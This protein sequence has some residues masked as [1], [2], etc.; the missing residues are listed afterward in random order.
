MFDELAALSSP[1]C[2]WWNAVGLICFAAFAL[3]A[4]SGLGGGTKLNRHRRIMNR[5]GCVAAL[6]G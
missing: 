4:I 2:L 5:I 1:E 3:M 6:G